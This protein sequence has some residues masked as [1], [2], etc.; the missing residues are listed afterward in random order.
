MKLN[1]SVKSI[2]ETSAILKKLKLDS[3]QLLSGLGLPVEADYFAVNNKLFAKQISVIQ[4]GEYRILKTNNKVTEIK[5]QTSSSLQG[6]TYTGYKWGLGNGV[7]TIT[8]TGPAGTFAVKLN[9][10]KD[11]TSHIEEKFFYEKKQTIE[12]AGA[13]MAVLGALNTSSPQTD[14]SRFETDI[15][16]PLKELDKK[17]NNDD[18]KLIVFEKSMVGMFVG[19]RDDIFDDKAL[20]NLLLD[21][22]RFS[23]GI[24][25]NAEKNKILAAINI[26]DSIW[27]KIIKKLFKALQNIGGKVLRLK[28]SKISEISV[29]FSTLSTVWYLRQMIRLHNFPGVPDLKDWSPDFVSPRSETGSGGSSHINWPKAERFQEEIHYLE[30]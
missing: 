14:F 18:Y 20:N 28:T 7:V 26:V 5:Q 3:G 10:W 2:T 17:F 8:W 29:L 11:Q 15:M 6:F 27:L 30:S 9:T 13:L 16:T 4:G 24:S 1:L 19:N 25:G 12:L 21:L 22:I 23:A